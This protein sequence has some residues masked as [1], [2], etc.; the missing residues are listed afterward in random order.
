MQMFNDE[1][2]HHGVK[3][4]R[5]GFRRYQNKDGTL[6]PAGRKR[7]N[8]LRNEYLA[9]TGKKQL[10]GDN[11]KT[12]SGSK[13][14]EKP[15]QKSVSEM[16]DEELQKVINRKRLEQQYAQLSPKKVS[17]G[18]AFVDKVLLPAASEAGKKALSSY[19]EKQFRAVLK[20]P[21]TDNGKKN[22][23]KKTE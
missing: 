15:K 2:Y 18:K 20:V 7:A 3:G 16:S 14:Q 23:K 19:M 4:Q 21:N 17:A 12:S 10:R 6:T 13:T 22:T 11:H 9:I 5:W 1:L 8:K